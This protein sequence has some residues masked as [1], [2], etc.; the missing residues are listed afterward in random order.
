MLAEI[1]VLQLET[2]M[3]DAKETNG[4]EAPLFFPSDLSNFSKSR[5]GRGKLSL[6]NNEF[7]RFAQ[8]I[9]GDACAD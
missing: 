5:S 9:I 3:R 2:K 7:E 1:F 4:P 8:R 6:R